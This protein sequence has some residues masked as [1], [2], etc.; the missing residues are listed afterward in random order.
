LEAL[1]HS[2]AP[3]AQPDTRRPQD[4]GGL[5]R[6]RGAALST[7]SRGAA[8]GDGQEGGS[9]GVTGC[10]SRSTKGKERWHD[11]LRLMDRKGKADGLLGKALIHLHP[12]NKK[13]VNCNTEH[14]V[15]N[16]SQVLCSKD[17]FKLLVCLK[18]FL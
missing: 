15:Q 13:G 2:S 17:A 12:P 16:P 1:K 11:F 14:Q 18:N 9:R 8:P 7:H 6:D 10:L 4:A 5:A 3:Q